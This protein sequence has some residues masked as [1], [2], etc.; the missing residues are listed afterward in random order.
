MYAIDLML[1][2]HEDSN[3]NN[4]K[5]IEPMICEINFMPGKQFLR[6]LI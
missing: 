3:N 1:D 6:V 2:W 4:S 5:T